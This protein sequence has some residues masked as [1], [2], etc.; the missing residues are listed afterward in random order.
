MDGSK[1]SLPIGESKRRAS[2]CAGKLTHNR[3]VGMLMVCDPMLRLDQTLATAQRSIS[4]T[5]ASAQGSPFRSQ[6]YKQSR[7][8]R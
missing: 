1:P 6:Y 3:P 5:F 8:E 2:H 7:E 4:P